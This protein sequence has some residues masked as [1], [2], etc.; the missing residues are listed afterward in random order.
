MN[1][2][3]DGDSLLPYS[4]TKQVPIVGT[5]KDTEYNKVYSYTID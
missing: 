1:F 3:D 4:K 2:L 5:S